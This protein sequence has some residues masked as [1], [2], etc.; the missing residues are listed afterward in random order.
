MEN[1]STIVP[2]SADIRS[3]ADYRLLRSSVADLGLTPDE[4]LLL[5]MMGHT[6]DQAKTVYSFQGLRRATHLHQAQLTKA[7]NRLSAKGDVIKT[8]DGYEL[9]EAGKKIAKNL[10]KEWLKKS[11]GKTNF[12]HFLQAKGEI[13]EGKLDNSTLN[14][15]K[16]HFYG[17]WFAHL[18]FY[19]MTFDKG[20]LQVNWLGN[21]PREVFA[22]L[23]FIPPRQITASVQ[24]N[25]EETLRTSLQILTD[26]AKNEL[27][28]EIALD[29]EFSFE[30]Y[31]LF[32]LEY[33][34]F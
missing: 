5:M 13:T 10:A 18:R 15:L 28:E 3:S 4:A 23:T 6:P 22:S 19:S 20:Y 29:A 16:K 27:K 25:D 21:N 24:S 30:D 32:G 7:L 31:D 12:A 11:L 17:K 34:A 9:T 2:G 26:R 1:P 14:I 33:L 8:T